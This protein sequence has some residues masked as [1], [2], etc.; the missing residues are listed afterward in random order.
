MSLKFL[1]CIVIWTSVIF[2][3]FI[4]A[5]GLQSRLGEVLVVLLWS[6]YAL[7]TCFS[8]VAALRNREDKQNHWIGVAVFSTAACCVFLFFNSGN[9][10]LGD[11]LISTVFADSATADRFLDLPAEDDFENRWERRRR[12]NNLGF[13]VDLALATV[14]T[15]LGRIS[16]TIPMHWISSG[17]KK[18]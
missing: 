4:A 13:L 16:T 17:S 2:G 3:A 1:L 15:V 7:F 14:M 12:L 18:Q 8:I 11:A 5:Q 9:D 6:T 10:S